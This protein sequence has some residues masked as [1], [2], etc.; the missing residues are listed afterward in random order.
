MRRFLAGLLLLLVIVEAGPAVTIASGGPQNDYESWIGRI[1]DGRLMIVFDRNPDWASGDIYSTFSDDD[2]LSWSEPQIAVS[3]F[4]D[5]A[6][7]SYVVTPDD[8][9]RLFYASNETGTYKIYEAVSYSCT[10]WSVRGIVDLGWSIGTNYYD[11]TVVVETDGSLTMSYV[12]AGVGVYIAHKPVDGTWDHDKVQ[13]ATS[14]YRPRIAKHSDG[15]YICAYH[16]RTGTSSQYD[17]FIRKSADL[18]DWSDPAQMTFNQ[19]SHDPFVI[20]LPDGS[21]ALYYA[22]HEALAYNLCRRISADGVTWESEEQITGDDVNN[23]QPHLLCEPG[24][25]FLVWAHAVDYPDDHD[26]YL[27][28]YAFEPQYLCGDCDSS[29]GVD[30]DDIVLLIGFVF[31]GGTSPDPVEAGDV[32]CSTS[33]DI[34]DIVYLIS[35]V[36][37]GGS[38]P[39]DPDSDGIPDC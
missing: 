12:V 33:I 37:A 31:Q 6:T 17:V 19:N 16:K 10:T 39:C 22:K 14:A 29:D 2:G 7:L 28:R 13:L 26:V 20:E 36:F 38:A 25:A 9:V 30:I 21:Y 32:N 34:D 18:I 4:G 35:Y 27:E 24:M 23:T 1:P 11:P 3:G 15:M 8:T 5:Q